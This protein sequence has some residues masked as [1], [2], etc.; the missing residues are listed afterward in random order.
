MQI[1]YKALA[2]AI[3][4]LAAAS[5]H[6]SLSLAGTSA[7]GGNGSVVF[8]GIKNPADTG[9]GST[10]N[11]ITIDL[12]QVF[13]DFL[14]GPGTQGVPTSQTTF[15]AGVLSAP[16]TT[17]VWDFRNNTEV[18]N[19]SARSGSFQYSSSFNSFLSAVG[20]GS[21]NWGVLSAERSNNSTTASATNPIANQNVLMSIADPTTFTSVPN[22]TAV[23][24]AAGYINNFYTE[25]NGLGTQVAGVIGANTATTGE[26]YLGTTIKTTNGDYTPDFTQLASGRSKSYVAWLQ[27]AATPRMFLLDGASDPVGTGNNPPV[28]GA[29]AASFTFDAVAGTLTYTVPVPEAGTT[30]MLL[31]GLAAVGFAVRRRVAS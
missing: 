31:L 3:A 28:L 26:S 14:P 29:L 6:A 13:S 24:T 27:Q 4:S 20:S 25:S 18:I 15:S 22:N 12:G 17:V 19:G 5:A 10:G 9:F 11:S 7:G 30:T 21:Y 1:R 2:V 8:V 16:G 23:S